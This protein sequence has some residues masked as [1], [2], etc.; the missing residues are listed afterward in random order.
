MK[1]ANGLSD[2]AR[3]AQPGKY[4]MCNNNTHHCP[5]WA[6]MTEEERHQRANDHWVTWFRKES[7]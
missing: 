6:V 2:A 1:G 4:I 3:Q 7:K 5:T